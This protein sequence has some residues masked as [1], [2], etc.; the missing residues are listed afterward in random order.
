MN[1]KTKQP[2]TCKHFKKFTFDDQLNI[3]LFACYATEPF[4]IQDIQDAVIDAHKA[5]I[6]SQLQNFVEQ[7]YLEKIADNK[8][9][10]TLYAKD[11]MNV[12]GVLI[13]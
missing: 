2:S 9:R 1:T 8:Y 11:I 4:S 5:T 12:K 13:A 3:L 7:R 6:H 10:A